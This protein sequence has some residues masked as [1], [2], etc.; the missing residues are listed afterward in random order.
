MAPIRS[1]GQTDDLIRDKKIPLGS[2]TENE[3]GNT[4]QTIPSRSRILESDSSKTNKRSFPIRHFTIFLVSVVFIII[5]IIMTKSTSSS[6]HKQNAKESK[7]SRRK[8]TDKSSNKKRRQPRIESIVFDADA[9]REHLTGMSARKAARRTYGLAMQKVKDR[10]TKL[11]QRAELR[12]ATRDRV[13]AAEAAREAH[14]QETLWRLQKAKNTKPKT[15]TTSNSNDE[16]HNEQDATTV[17]QYEGQDTQEHWGGRVV[18]TTSTHIPDSDDDDDEQQ[19]QQ[20]E[21]K[22]EEK[23]SQH[24]DDDKYNNDDVKDAK[25]SRST[26]SAAKSHDDQQEYAGQVE[27]YLKQLKGQAPT[28]K[29]SST[30]PGGRRGGTHGASKM[31]GVG[32]AATLKIAQRVLARSTAAT[33]TKGRGGP[34]KKGKQSRKNPTKR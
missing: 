3:N 4:R 17:L 1:G 2:S 15:T 28:K 6:N 22:G 24:D 11:A 8:D 32:S 19:Q 26:A 10:T 31:K 27:K 34:N 18:V 16:I 30:V 9:R 25:S 14:Q 20:Q 12:D 21:G 5:I 33:A 7:K 29:R 23:D 13:D